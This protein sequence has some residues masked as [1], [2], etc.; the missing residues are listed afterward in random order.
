MKRPKPPSD[1]SKEGR[2]LWHQIYDAV[3]LDAA[4]LVLLDT[5]CQ[6]WDRVQEARRAIAKQGAVVPGRFAGTFVANPWSQIERDSA[7]AVMR[8]WRLLGFDQEP[9]GPV[10][11]PP[12]V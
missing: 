8:A 11:R 2:A 4:A 7:A 12:G 3:E 5:M 10:G 1:L 6:Q 9:T